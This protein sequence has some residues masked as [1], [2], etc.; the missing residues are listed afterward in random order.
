MAKPGKI[1][2]AEAEAAVSLVK[3]WRGGL[4]IKWREERKIGEPEHAKARVPLSVNGVIQEG[5]FVDIY[6]KRSVI[7]GIPDKLSISLMFNNSRVFGL[8]ENGPTRHLNKVGQGLEHFRQPVS[9]PHVHYPV[10]DGSY[11]YAEPIE[12]LP[13]DKL[14]SLFCARANILNAPPFN[15]PASDGQMDLL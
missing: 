13:I 12:R 14:W 3:T 1:G 7:E 4:F 5:L 15:L 2:Y 9:T 6:Y 8:D 10:P 11:G